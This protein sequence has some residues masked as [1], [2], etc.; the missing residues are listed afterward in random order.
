MRTNY[1]SY[2]H[3][4]KAFLPFFQAKQNP[5]AIVFVTSG[6]ALAPLTRC[7]NYCA[8]KAALHSLIMSMRFQL[9]QSG[10]GD[11]KVIE[12]LPP[13]V[14]SK[15]IHYIY[16]GKLMLAFPQAE[17]HDAKHQPDIKDGRSIGMPLNEFTDAAWA[18]LRDGKDS[19]PVGQTQMGF[20]ALEP[21]RKKIFD[22]MNS[23]FKH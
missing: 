12:I 3:L 10:K 20:D 5:T 14:Q 19:I 9:E 18:G 17:L 6:L 7:P 16:G 21:A 8:S 22:H 2:I 13:A 1:F 15:S 4:V 23:Q 11:I